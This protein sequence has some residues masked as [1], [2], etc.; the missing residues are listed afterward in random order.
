MKQR[1]TEAR[2]RDSMTTGSLMWNRSPQL[3]MEGLRSERHIQT[4]GMVALWKELKVIRQQ[5]PIFPIIT[6]ED[7]QSITEQQKLWRWAIDNKPLR[8]RTPA[9][10]KTRNV[11]TMPHQLM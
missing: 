11:K 2:G 4:A 10:L 7:A 3:G 8:T 6:S 1:Y 5:A 9:K